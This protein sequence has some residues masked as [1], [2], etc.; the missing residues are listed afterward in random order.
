M[1]ARVRAVLRF[2]RY[3]AQR[4][5]NDEKATVD[6]EMTIIEKRILRELLVGFRTVASLSER[7]SLDAGYIS[8]MVTVLELNRQV[9]KTVAANDR[10]E[11]EIALTHWG[12]RVV[13]DLEEDQ[14]QRTRAAL[15]LLPQRQQKRLVRAMATITE[16]F[17]RDGLANFLECARER[18]SEPP[19]RRGRRAS[20]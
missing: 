10:R 5:W 17:E 7:L 18:L 4:L 11:R 16:V 8:R 15:E 1:E 2:D 12:R 3:Y 9:A 19:P 13:H 14:E 6:L 20:A